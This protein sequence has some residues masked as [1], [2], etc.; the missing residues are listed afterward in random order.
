MSTREP[1]SAGAGATSLALQLGIP[2]DVWAAAES[3]L[4]A[5]APG[6]APSALLPDAATDLSALLPAAGPDA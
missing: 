6:T 3:G 4:A 5:T 2:T 1:T